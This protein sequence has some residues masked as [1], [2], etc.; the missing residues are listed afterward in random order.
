MKVFRQAGH[1][2]RVKAETTAWTIRLTITRN[3]RFRVAW[4]L[5]AA[6][7]RPQVV[8]RLQEGGAGGEVPREPGPEAIVLVGR[9]VTAG[10]GGVQVVAGRGG[11]LETRQR[12]G[13]GV[14]GAGAVADEGVGA[15]VEKRST[16]AP[17]RFPGGRV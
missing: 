10:D 17:L 9:E 8:D 5:N 14:D 2:Q 15:H 6:G 7:R 12:R 16:D 4:H 3:V 1:F 13:E 11:R